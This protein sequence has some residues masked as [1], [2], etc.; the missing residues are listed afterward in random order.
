MH[1][2]ISLCWSFTCHLFLEVP[3]WLSIYEDVVSFWF[4]LRQRKALV[5]RCSECFS[6]RYEAKVLVSLGISEHEFWWKDY[7]FS[8]VM[9]LLLTKWPSNKLSKLM[10][11]VEG[12]A[13]WLHGRNIVHSLLSFPPKLVSYFFFIFLLQ[14]HL[15][16]KITKTHIH[17]LSLSPNRKCKKITKEKNYRDIFLHQHKRKLQRQ[18]ILKIASLLDRLLVHNWGYL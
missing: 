16:K 15:N 6:F 5:P 2:L 12:S 11:Y 13:I 4:F 14:W 8:L 9:H 3:T 18:G 10:L 1:K 17:S 7:I